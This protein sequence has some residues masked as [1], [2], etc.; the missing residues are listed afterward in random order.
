MVEDDS[1]VVKTSTFCCS[2]HDGVLLIYM[3]KKLSNKQGRRFFQ[4]VIREC[5][6]PEDF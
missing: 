4:E 5:L 3:T 1:I 2:S 6:I